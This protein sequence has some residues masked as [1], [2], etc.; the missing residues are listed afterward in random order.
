MLNSTGADPRGLDD[1]RDC[2]PVAMARD[3]TVNGHRLGPAILLELVVFPNM[4]SEL[5][6]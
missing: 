2:A 1:V 5:G 3:G 6:Q 4:A